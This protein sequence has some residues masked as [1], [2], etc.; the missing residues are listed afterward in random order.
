MTDIKNNNN[1]LIKPVQKELLNPA[2]DLA[3]DYA[4]I[5]LDTFFDNELLS[6]LPFIKSIVGVG[7]IGWTIK[8]RHD[9]KKL[10][11]FFKE[12]QSGNV[13]EKNKL[14]FQKK[15]NSNKKYRTKVLETIVLLNER[16]LGIKK[17]RV[18]A[19]LLNAHINKELSWD[20]LND[21]TIVLNSMH[22]KGFEFLNEMSEL[23]WCYF[24]KVREAE[25]LMFSCGIG[26]RN[27]TKFSISELGQK[28]F[29]FG[30]KPIIV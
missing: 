9:L 15:I 22:P 28:M 17:S 23:N 14:D 29:Y 27:G 20:D 26:Y 5:S 10:L 25:P 18:L 8:E 4:E 16:F 30:I 3:I 13:L 7:K 6:E 21:I 12:F 2:L 11:V 19:N 1:S 24:Y